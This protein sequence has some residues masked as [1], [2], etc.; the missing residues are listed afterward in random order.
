MRRREGGKNPYSVSTETA[1]R[2]QFSRRPRDLMPPAA[3]KEGRNG[4]TDT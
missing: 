4:K 2:A 1:A 3:G